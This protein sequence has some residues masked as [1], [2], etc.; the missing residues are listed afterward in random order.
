MMLGSS[1]AKNDALLHRLVHTRLLSG[2]LN[3]ELNLTRGQRQ[4]ALQGR[5]LELA[6]TAKLGKGDAVVRH[7]ERNQA[8]KRVR[9]GLERK[10][11]ERQ[12]K[13]LEEVRLSVV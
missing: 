8:S 13:A 5:L 11:K 3:S 10:V 9:L 4:K 7:T 6:D 1:N 2:S 12:E